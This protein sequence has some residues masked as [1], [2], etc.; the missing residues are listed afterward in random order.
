MM[1][2][3]IKT[4]LFIVSKYTACYLTASDDQ[5]I[6][7]LRALVTLTGISENCPFSTK[8]LWILLKLASRA[9]L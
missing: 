4:I 6:Y 1:K 8:Y 7:I 3:S 9:V 2:E 5:K